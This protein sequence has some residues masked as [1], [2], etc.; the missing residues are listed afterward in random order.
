[1]LRREHHRVRRPRSQV[2]RW[3]GNGAIA[4][5]YGAK[6]GMSRAAND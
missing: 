2:D 3:A 1:M 4:F 6:F 5:S